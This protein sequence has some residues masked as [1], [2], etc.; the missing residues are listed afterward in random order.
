MPNFPQTV[1]PPSPASY[2]APQLN[3]NNFANWF[4]DFQQGEQGGQQQQLYDQKIATGQRQQ[5][6][7]T[8]FPYGL[9]TD[10]NGQ[11]DTKEIAQTLAKFGAITDAM[12]LV[13]QQPIPLSPL[14]SWESRY[15]RQLCERGSARWKSL[16]RRP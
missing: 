4:K 15:R 7:A 3:F 6:L 12:T 1:A 14:H 9:P 8:A 13:Q 2:D 16:A 5:Q 10:E 11:L